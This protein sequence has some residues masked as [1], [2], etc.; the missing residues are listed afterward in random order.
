MEAETL[1]KMF[2]APKSILSRETPGN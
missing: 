2:G 1:V